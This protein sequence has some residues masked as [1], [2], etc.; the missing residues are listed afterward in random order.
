L[1]RLN[2]PF[3]AVVIRD[4]WVGPGQS[5]V[6]PPAVHYSAPVTVPSRPEK[7][8]ARFPC[9]DGLRALAALSVVGVHT[10]FVS[11]FTGRSGLGNYAARLEIGVA[12][13]FVISGFLLYRPFALAHFDGRGASMRGFWTRRLKR[14]IPAYWAAFF[15]VTY[16]MHADKVRHGW[17]A[18]AVYLGFAQI[19]SPHYVLTG[20]T[21]AWSLCTEMAFYLALPLWAWCVGRRRR[22]PAT[23]L[24]LEVAGLAGW[25]AV[26]LIYRGIVLSA[27]G[28][29]AM[30]M[31]NW[32]PG[33]TDL[34]ALGMLLAVFSAWSTATGRSPRLLDHSA[35]PWVSWALAG[36]MFVAVSDI[37]LP[38][39]PV[40]PSPLGLSLS[41]QTLY[42]L[43]AFFVVAPAVIGPQDRGLIRRMLQT[44]PLVFLGSVSYGIYLWHESWI[45][46]FLRWTGDRLFTISF[47]ELLAFVTLM[48]TVTAAVSY[49]GVE[50]PIIQGRIRVPRRANPKTLPVPEIQTAAGPVAPA[51]A[52]S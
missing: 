25:V 12:V 34:F 47:P 8:T 11:G 1:G 19:Y 41:R 40:T 29:M 21:Q 30:T 37:G 44:K 24:R 4:V 52:Q 10:T 38:L 13:F 6:Q 3:S 45:L 2:E 35:L 22:D 9:F 5:T 20:I 51:G 46:M 42:G 17:G 7:K 33:T 48:A 26:G 18:L 31:A 50:L 32:L 27:H 43:F 23:Q 39:T 16:V 14:I 15:V 36:L 28:A 49:Y